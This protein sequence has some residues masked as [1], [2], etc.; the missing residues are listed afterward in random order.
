M[1]ELRQAAVKGAHSCRASSPFAD[2]G[3]CSV[4]RIKKT[5]VRTAENVLTRRM[6]LPDAGRPAVFSVKGAYIGLFGGGEN[7]HA[8][9][10]RPKVLPSNALLGPWHPKSGSNTT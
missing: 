4:T 10:R 5:F 3:L 8:G 2:G 7:S 1:D 9:E 6:V